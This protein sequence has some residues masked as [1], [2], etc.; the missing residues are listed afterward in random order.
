MEIK[1]TEKEVQGLAEIM[2]IY[3]KSAGLKGVN[4]VNVIMNSIKPI[5]P[6]EVQLDAEGEADD[7]R[8][9]PVQ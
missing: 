7:G 9:E 1:A 5:K 6:N 4:N 2:D 3:V 8:E